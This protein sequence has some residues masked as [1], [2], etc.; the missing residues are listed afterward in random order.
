M[1]RARPLKDSSFYYLTWTNAHFSCMWCVAYKWDV[2]ATQSKMWE[3]QEDSSNRGN[4]G[5][6]YL[7]SF[8]TTVFLKEG[9]CTIR[10]QF[11]WTE[12]QIPQETCWKS[13]QFS[14]LYSTWAFLYRAFLWM[15]WSVTPWVPG[16]NRASRPRGLKQTQQ[17]VHSL[18]HQNQ[19]KLPS[20]LLL[21]RL[22]SQ[23]SGQGA[24]RLWA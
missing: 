2:F 8:L 3:K 15:L 10:N 22:Y 7:Y 23:A 16:R 20:V 6:A 24:V 9:I 13:G 14:G 19:R 12:T 1:K 17:K 18:C 21:T 11:W 4:V 5:Q